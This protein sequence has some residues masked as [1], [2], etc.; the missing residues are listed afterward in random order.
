MY[1]CQL[2]S[3][4]V[5]P[6][7]MIFKFW[8]SMTC[9]IVLTRNMRETFLIFHPLYCLSYELFSWYMIYFTMFLFF[10]YSTKIKY[11]HHNVKKG[12]KK[13]LLRQIWFFIYKDKELI[14]A[15][16]SLDI[17]G[18]CLFD[19]SVSTKQSRI[20]TGKSNIRSCIF[21][22]NYS[23]SVSPSGLFKTDL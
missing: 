15:N 11:L 10:Y 16:V 17:V 13:H 1:F 9:K 3:W 4:Q 6:Y 18:V 5:Y 8:C 20:T 22:F 21:I 7:E 12:D 2:Y 14:W 23:D 19:L